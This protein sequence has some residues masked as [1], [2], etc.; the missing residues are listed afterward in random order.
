MR[1]AVVIAMLVLAGCDAKVSVGS[2]PTEARHNTV[3]A[4]RSDGDRP[5]GHISYALGGGSVVHEF[6]LSNGTLCVTRQD[7]GITC[8]W[9]RP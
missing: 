3:A 2:R 5:A 7:S 6:R 8:G 4:A 1:A 9:G